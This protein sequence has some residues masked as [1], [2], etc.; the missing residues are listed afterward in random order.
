MGK[1][2]GFLEFTRELPAKR[3]PQERI[4]DFNEFVERFPEPKL[5]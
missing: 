5:N 3:P 1:P 4:H 2:T